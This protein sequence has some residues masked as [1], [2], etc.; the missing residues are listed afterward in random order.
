MDFHFSVTLLAG[1]RTRSFSHNPRYTSHMQLVSFNV[2]GDG[3]THTIASISGAPKKC[4]WFQFQL[5]A[6]ALNVGG[7]DTDASHGFPVGVLSSQ[8]TPPIAFINDFYDLDK[9]Y[10]FMGNGDEAVLLCAY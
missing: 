1:I 3:A 10:Y 2:T 7:P 4:K 8:F 6:G 5:N 9:I